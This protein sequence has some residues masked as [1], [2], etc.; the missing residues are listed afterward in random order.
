VSGIEHHQPGEF[1]G[2]ARCDDFAA[3]SAFGQERQPPSM[4]EMGVRQQHKI[5]AGGIETK[6]AGVFFGK[7]AAAL[8]E[9]AVDQK[10]PAGAL[11]EMA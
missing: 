1:A 2:S 10:A 8:I 11:D 6:V 5:D 9:S 4:I 3:K 7:L